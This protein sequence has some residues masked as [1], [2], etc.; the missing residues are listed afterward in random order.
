MSVATLI[1][2]VMKQLRSLDIFQS[3]STRRCGIVG[4]SVWRLVNPAFKIKTVKQTNRLWQTLLQSKCIRLRIACSLKEH[5]KS[6]KNYLRASLVSVTDDDTLSAVRISV[7]KTLTIW[8]F[9]VFG[10]PYGERSTT[11]I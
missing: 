9:Q 6:A 4:V 7:E 2:T 8:K 5:Q 3:K 11:K 1:S 10:I